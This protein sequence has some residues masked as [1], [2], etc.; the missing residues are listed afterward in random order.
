[1]NFSTSFYLGVFVVFTFLLYGNTL[2]H[3]FV[4]DDSIVI[5]ENS[6][7]KQGLS[8]IPSIFSTE[9]MV[10]FYGQ[11]KSLVSGGRY[12]P[13]SIAVFAL[14]HQVFGM[15]A[16]VFHLFTVLFYLT[17]VLLLFKVLLL[18]FKERIP[19]Q[20]QNSVRFQ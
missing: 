4:L 8:G 16:K 13:L 3:D 17:N 15:N 20:S 7:V 19:K 12:R 1:M 5:T 6:F 18:L 2:N 9:S 11:Q 10:G 14:I